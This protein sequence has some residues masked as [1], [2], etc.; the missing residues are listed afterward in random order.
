MKR[1]ISNLNFLVSLM[2]VDQITKAI[3]S[4]RDFFCG[5]I[6]ISL[7]KN[8]GLPFGIQSR[9]WVSFI[10]AALVLAILIKYYYSNHGSLSRTENFGFILIFA[11]AASNILDRIIYGYVRDLFDIGWG[12]VFN[13]ADVYIVLG[14]LLVSLNPRLKSSLSNK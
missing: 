2:V 4:T 9:S 12:F 13:F 10:I 8:F 14:I 5:L 1:Y 6:A 7:V 11:G 3:L